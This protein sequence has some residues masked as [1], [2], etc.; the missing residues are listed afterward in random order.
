MLA[1]YRVKFTVKQK[2]FCKFERWKNA[3]ANRDLSRLHDTACC[4]IA[5]P[6]FI[7]LKE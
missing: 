6:D 2:S 4:L 3:R 5:R 1:V 7:V